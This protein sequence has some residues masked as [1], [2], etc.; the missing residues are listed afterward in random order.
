MALDGIDQS[1]TKKK[2]VRR[3][4]AGIPKPE[5]TTGRRQIGG[6]SL[7]E[8]D[9][10]RFA[11]KAPE[12][13]L[14]RKDQTEAH[15]RHRARTVGRLRLAARRWNVARA[16]KPALGQR[17]AS[18]RCGFPAAVRTQP[19]TALTRPRARRA[20]EAATAKANV[21]SATPMPD[22]RKLKRKVF[23]M[24]FPLTVVV[25]PPGHGPDAVEQE[26]EDRQEHGKPQCK[27]PAGFRLA[28]FGGNSA[29]YQNEA[30][31]RHKMSK[32]QEKRGFTPLT[33]CWLECSR[34]GRRRR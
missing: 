8:T 9:R 6:N 32:G 20:I 14:P 25:R 33:F 30:Y 12:G 26:A 31:F 22:Q 34:E 13:A 5:A 29:V 10:L 11:E 27:K 4:A 28:G 15:M 17:S 19:T 3:L 24:T 21:R 23:A 7:S 2:R 18:D 16:F 1:P